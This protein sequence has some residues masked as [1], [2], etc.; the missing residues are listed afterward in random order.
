[1]TPQP[2]PTPIVVAIDGSQA[3]LEAALWAVDEAAMRGTAL[4]LVH[5]IDIE[6]EIYRDL[7]DDPAEIARDWPEAESGRASLSAAA[8]AVRGVG[9]SVP[10]ET[11][12]LWGEID[13]T[14]IEESRTATMVC[15]GSAGISPLCHSVIGSTAATLAERALSPV[16]VIRSPRSSTA[17][18]P[19]WIV[20]VVDGGPSSDAI[21]ACALDEA[22]MRRAPVLA[23]WIT[24]RDRENIRVDDLG[25]RTAAWTRG[26]PDL[27]IHP[28]VV[29][30][31]VA[32]FLQQHNDLSVQLTIVGA[33]DAKDTVAIVGPRHRTRQPRSRCSLLVVR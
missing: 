24:R 32:G 2:P 14:L 26:R 6:D 25:R 12:I 28:G 8:A 11:Q 29:T 13:L 21:V 3:A 10:I 17:S 15:L 30:T 22:R 9:T 18:E 31:D 27:H 33:V 5:V 19:T 23:V 1:M 20:A 7:D 16:A 4:R